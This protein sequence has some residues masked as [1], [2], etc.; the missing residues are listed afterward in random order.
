MRVDR[1]CCCD[2]SHGAL[3]TRAFPRRVRCQNTET[4]SASRGCVVLTTAATNPATVTT[5]A[6]S[7][8]IPCFNAEHFVAAT[9]RSVLAQGVDGVEVVV[10]DD[11]SSDAS[12]AV[13]AQMSG[14]VRLIRQPNAGV[15]V[16]R[17]TGLQAA[18]GRL[19]AFLDADDIWLPGKLA[20]QLALLE[21]NPGVRMCCSAWEVWNSLEPEPTPELFSHLSQQLGGAG[22]A[23]EG[24]SGWIY[25]ELLLD[26]VVWTS[27]VLAE[28]SLFSEIGAFDPT[29]RIGEDYD[30]WLRASRVTPILR[31]PRPLALYRM[32]P[33]SITKGAARENFKAQV[34]GRALEKWGLSS[35]D[36][37]QADRAAVQRTLAR[38]WSDF[39]GS[40]LDAGD[41]E[42]ARRSAWR[43]L[44]FAP[45][46]LLAWKI[47]A[48]SLVVNQ[49]GR[50]VRHG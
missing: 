43:A 13:V 41:S 27:T 24:A 12:A 17:N 39:A 25:P 23:W 26:C 50:G 48:K 35:P 42:Q 9:L 8:V 45:G 6:I 37:R 16:A 4:F 29:L 10:V 49:G 34:I 31:V 46:Q 47:L 19:V 7:V 3:A 36:G 32:H 22:S 2:G 40:Q 33:T 38:S 30:L 44:R 18:R 5:P 21:T 1:R 20:A 28:R 11:G 14:D 15:A